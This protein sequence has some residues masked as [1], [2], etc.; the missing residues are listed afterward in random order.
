MDGVDT[1]SYSYRDECSFPGWH[2]MW[3]VLEGFFD[4]L[5]TANLRNLTHVGGDLMKNPNDM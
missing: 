3:D 5:K 1:V 2:R 4:S